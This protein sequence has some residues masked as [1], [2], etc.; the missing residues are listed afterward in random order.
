VPTFRTG[1][2]LY[3]RQ[4]MPGE[5]SAGQP[6]NVV[7]ANSGW[8]VRADIYYAREYLWFPCQQFALGPQPWPVDGSS[9]PMSDT[10][11]VVYSAPREWRNPQWSDWLTVAVGLLFFQALP[12]VAVGV[13]T[14]SDIITFKKTLAATAVGVATFS[15]KISKLMAA[16]AIGV[17]TIV[18]KVSKTLAA[19]AVGVASM[20]TSK[21][22]LKTLS[23]TAVGVAVLSTRKTILKTLTAIAVGVASLT[24]LFLPAV[25]PNTI[26]SKLKRFRTKLRGR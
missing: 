4:F 26:I 22:I 13:A 6:P 7:G 5:I 18:K 12:A 21:T 15:K 2:N 8:R 23:A 1:A 24:T 14:M 3:C 16:T 11:G 10:Q 25:P 19:T 9:L 20:T 17:A